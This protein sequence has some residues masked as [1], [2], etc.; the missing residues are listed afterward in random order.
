MGLYF[1]YYIVNIILIWEWE[2]L[3]CHEILHLFNLNFLC[4]WYSHSVIILLCL[5]IL[6]G[7]QYCYNVFWRSTLSFQILALDI[8][9]I[10]HNRR[11]VC[12]LHLIFFVFLC[13]WYSMCPYDWGLYLMPHFCIH[14]FI[15]L[16]T[17][18]F[19]FLQSLLIVSILEVS[20]HYFVNLVT[21]SH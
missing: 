2:A 3:A 18:E 19:L 13:G 7:K 6:I 1:I 21:V 8:C 9:S 11:V 10:I 15:F 4:N 16:C 17:V 5:I 20:G 14:H 12:Q